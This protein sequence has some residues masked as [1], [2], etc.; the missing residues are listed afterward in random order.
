MAKKFNFSGIL[1][2]NGKRVI[3]DINVSVS[4]VDS[5]Q[6]AKVVVSG[7][8]DG[9]TNLKFEIPS[10]PQGSTGPQ[11]EKGADGQQGPVGPTGPQGATGPTGPAITWTTY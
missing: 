9:V 3:T 11:G 6:P 5:D 4:I 8:E 1:Q 2:E 10:G 7:T